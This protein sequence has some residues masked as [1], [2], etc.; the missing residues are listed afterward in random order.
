MA[1]L[2]I[3]DA[4]D[5]DME[6]P[7]GRQRDPGV[8]ADMGRIGDERVVVEALILVRIGYDQGLA[9]VDDMPAEGD[10]SRG[11]ACVDP[12]RRLEPLAMAVD[13]GEG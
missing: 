6:P 3:L 1:G 5:P 4:Q 12:T 2:G 7:G 10:L 13:K 8:E 9:V 11:L